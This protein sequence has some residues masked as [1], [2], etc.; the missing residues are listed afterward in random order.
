MYNYIGFT[1]F[2]PTLGE[3]VKGGYPLFDDSWATFVPEHKKDLCSKIIDYYYFNQIG[4]DTPDKFRHFL[5]AQM[6]L[7]MTYYN[8]LYENK[9]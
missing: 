1:D 5:N 6:R 7:R 3:L 9:M 4:A 8:Q 2:N